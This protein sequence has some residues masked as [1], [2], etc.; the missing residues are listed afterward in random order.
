ME[1]EKK[2]RM[3]FG[4]IGGI[5]E[6]LVMQ[7]FD[8]IKVRRQSNQYI[9]LS[10]TIKQNGVLNLYKGLTPFMGQMSVKYALRFGTFELLRGKSDVFYKNFAAGATAGFVESLFITPFELIKTNLQ[11]RNSIADPISAIKRVKLEKGIKGMYRGFTSTCLRQSINQGSNFTI[12]MKLRE[13]IIKPGE[14][15]NI[16]MVM[17]AA[18]ISGSAGPLLN[19]PFDVV[20]TRYMNPGFDNKYNGILDCCQKI[21]RTEGVSSLYKGLGLRLFRVS[22]GQAITF[23]VIEQLSHYADQYKFLI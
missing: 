21:I 7:P 14:K 23:S 1:K 19:N 4:P 12:Y 15:P 11:T 8:T 18:L 22:C 6:A 13:K 20:K 10:K 5:C 17:G 3:A 16:P 2:R 9:G